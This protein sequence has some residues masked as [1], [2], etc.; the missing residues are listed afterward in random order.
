MSGIYSVLEAYL[1]KRLKIEK[2]HGIMMEYI[3]TNKLQ[4]CEKMDNI[5]WTKFFGEFLMPEKKIKSQKITKCAKKAFEKVR[6]DKIT[7]SI[8]YYFVRISFQSSDKVNIFYMRDR[9][10]EIKIKSYL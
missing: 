10:F 8:I 6:F 1:I 3:M 5:N 9:K 2:F 4:N 7:S